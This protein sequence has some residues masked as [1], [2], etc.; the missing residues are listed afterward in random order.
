MLEV[1]ELESCT[2]FSSRLTELSSM[3]VFPD[4]P[5]QEIKTKDIK[6]KN[7]TRISDIIKKNTYLI[8][9]G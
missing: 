3:E 2:E 9:T 4:P 5:S 8:N 6:I 7:C 1:S